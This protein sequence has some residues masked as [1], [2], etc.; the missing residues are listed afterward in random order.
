M[1]ILNT[2]FHFLFLYPFQ[3]NVESVAAKQFVSENMLSADDNSEMVAQLRAW[4][5]YQ[6]ASAEARVMY[7]LSHPNILG[8]IGISLRPLM[9][10]VELAPQGDL[11]K[12]VERFRIKKVRLSQTT[13]QTTLVQV[14]YIVLLTCC[15]VELCYA[16][17]W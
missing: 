16:Q 5:I 2:A 7:Q 1:Y 3:G 14:S 12:C 13:L 17:K 8:L 4:D 6:K 15:I 11:K 10:L 9:L